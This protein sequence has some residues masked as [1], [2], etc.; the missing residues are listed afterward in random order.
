MT[1][2]AREAILEIM[3]IESCEVPVPLD[4][5]VCEVIDSLGFTAVVWDIEH[6]IERDLPDRDLAGLYAGTVEKFLEY[7]LV[8][9]DCKG[10]DI[11]KLGAANCP[12]CHGTGKAR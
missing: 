6:E 10:G 1:R 5:K 8:C 4:A 2:V 12:T 11:G 9:P 3:E 7:V